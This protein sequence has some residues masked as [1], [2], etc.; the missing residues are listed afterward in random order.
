VLVNYK[1]SVI[2]IKVVKTNIRI[3]YQ[4]INLLIL[5]KTLMTTCHIYNFGIL[6]EQNITNNKT[7]FK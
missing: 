4:K 2:R 3:L 6:F 5:L 1:Y 7:T